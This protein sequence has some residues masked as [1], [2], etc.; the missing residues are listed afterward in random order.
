MDENGFNGID[1]MNQSVGYI[2][3][4]CVS[5]CAMCNWMKGSLDSATFIKRIR[6]I[7]SFYNGLRT[8]MHPEC[9]P[10]AKC[11]SYL[12]YKNRAEKK[13]L[14]FVITK[15]EYKSI[16]LQDCYLCGKKST[17]TNING[18]DRSDN[19]AGY[20]VENCKACC[21]ECNH[22]KNNFALETLIAKIERIQDVWKYREVPVLPIQIY[23]I[24]QT[25]EKMTKEEIQKE[26]EERKQ[27]TLQ[28][29]CD[30]LARITVEKQ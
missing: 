23:S 29:H 11:V 16:I 18:I 26:R 20:I 7:H 24:S 15:D 22:M 4:N 6:H 12:S 19:T 3:S 25:F 30:Y 10:D 21:K 8:E 1:R 2:Q 27:R 14:V 13:N 9:F 17:E 28:K 5:C